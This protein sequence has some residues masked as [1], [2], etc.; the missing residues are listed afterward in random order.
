MDTSLLN[1]ISLRGQQL[2]WMTPDDFRVQLDTSP[3]FTRLYAFLT[4]VVILTL[5]T[6][7]LFFLFYAPILITRSEFVEDIS[8]VLFG[9]VHFVLWNGYGIWFEWRWNGTTPGKRL[10]GIQVIRNEGGRLTFPAILVRNLIK[11]V[12]VWMPIRVLLILLI[13]HQVPYAFLGCFSLLLY[14]LLDT[15]NRRL[16]DV[17]AGT[18]VVKS[19]SPVELP[20]EVMQMRGEIEGQPDYFFSTDML[21]VYGKVQLYA[22]QEV[23]EEHLFSRKKRYRGGDRQTLLVDIKRKVVEKLD[24]P[25]EVPDD[26]AVDFLQ[27][28]YQS[29]RDYL[30]GQLISGRS[31]RDE[32]KE[33]TSA[34]TFRRGRERIKKRLL[35]RMNLDDRIEES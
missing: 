21:E 5:V 17:A 25:E 4:D 2:E 16:G 22:L 24:Y 13:G 6:V 8:V 3:L 14:P 33:D 26:E 10:A 27:S 1:Q 29:M 18:A 30:E 35:K 32:L 19:P 9:L 34:K 31:T 23:L 28:F 7:G 15:F 20:E 11:E 12:E